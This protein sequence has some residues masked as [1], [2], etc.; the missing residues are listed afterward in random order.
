MQ[1]TIFGWE[2]VLRKRR[3][4]KYHVVYPSNSAWTGNP[5]SSI[6]WQDPRGS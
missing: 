5:T 1:V 2:L 4:R 3:L 6:Y